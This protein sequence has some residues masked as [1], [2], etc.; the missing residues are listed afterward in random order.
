MEHGKYEYLCPVCSKGF[1]PHSCD[2]H[3]EVHIDADDV[4]YVMCPEKHKFRCQLVDDSIEGGGWLCELIDNTKQWPKG[5][6]FP[7]KG[8]PID[9]HSK[10]SG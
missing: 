4:L 3:E 5:T 1:H 6:E 8:I 9:Q 2:L 10:T 7:I